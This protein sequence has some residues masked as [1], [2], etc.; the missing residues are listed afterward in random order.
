M[1]REASKPTSILDSW[2]HCGR[3]DCE[4][5]AVDG[6]DVWSWWQS[7]ATDRPKA[8]YEVCEKHGGELVRM[9]KSDGARELREH[10]EPWDM[11]RKPPSIALRE[12]AA[13]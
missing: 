8:H 9:G 11:A 6:F 13:V 4:R 2:P 5:I 7:N 3:R 10:Y 1:T 12:M